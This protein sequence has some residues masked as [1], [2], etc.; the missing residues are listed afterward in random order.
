MV[1]DYIWILVAQQDGNPSL[2][3]FRS[4]LYDLIHFAAQVYH[5]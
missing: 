3:P 5:H 1:G 2:C 4:I